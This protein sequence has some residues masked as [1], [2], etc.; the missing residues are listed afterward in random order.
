MN[1]VTMS[2]AW[3]RNMVVEKLR[4]NKFD[5]CMR[6]AIID[7]FEND[8]KGLEREHLENPMFYFSLSFVT[9]VFI[10]FWADK[11]YE[12]LNTTC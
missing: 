5:C 3:F 12:R 11:T 7:Y 1:L 4:D 6:R 8:C 9:Q 2:P 10:L